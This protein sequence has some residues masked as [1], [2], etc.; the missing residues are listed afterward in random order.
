MSL[1]NETFEGTDSEDP[2]E[3]IDR[4]AF[5]TLQK[6]ADQ[7]FRQVLKFQQYVESAKNRREKMVKLLSAKAVQLIK[8][9]QPDLLG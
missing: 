5:A 7:P 1:E 4:T 6:L 2:T 9:T 3:H 8:E